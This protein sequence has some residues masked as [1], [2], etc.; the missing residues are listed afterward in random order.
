MSK[1]SKLDH[2]AE[3]IE[4]TK[5]KLSSKSGGSFLQNPDQNN[6]IHKAALGPNTKRR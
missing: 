2:E 5:K 4:N 1:N 3:T 6:D